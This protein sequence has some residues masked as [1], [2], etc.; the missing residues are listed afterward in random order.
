MRQ[1]EFQAITAGSFVG[2][3]ALALV[4]TGKAAYE[5]SVWSDTERSKTDL[6][7]IAKVENVQAQTSKDVADAYAKNQ[8]AHF[9]Q[10]IVRGY[11]LKNIPPRVDWQHSVNP[12][13]KTF[14][15]DQYRRCVGYA[16]KGR[17]YFVKHYQGVCNP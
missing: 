11:V 6:Q 2:L 5:Q 8:V 14:I 15:Y 10:L 7:A 12:N 13:K 4:T 16:H 17:F 3:G 9:D 1:G